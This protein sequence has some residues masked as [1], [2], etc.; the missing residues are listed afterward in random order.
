M[1]FFFDLIVTSHSCFAKKNSSG[2]IFKMRQMEFT[3]SFLKLEIDKQHAKRPFN[4]VSGDEAGSCNM[5]KASSPDFAPVASSSTTENCTRPVRVQ[6]TAN[7]LRLQ[8]SF[9]FQWDQ[10]E[11]R[12][13]NIAKFWNASL[14]R[15]NVDHWTEASYKYCSGAADTWFQAEVSRIQF[16]CQVRITPHK[17]ISAI[18]KRQDGLYLYNSLSFY[19]RDYVVKEA[20]IPICNVSHYVKIAESLCLR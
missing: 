13:Q 6:S 9:P 10:L 4:V 16:R 18:P 1:R 14:H 12:H 5:L 20:I 19:S 3:Y 8:S 17:V 15:P 7:T 2:V 11:G